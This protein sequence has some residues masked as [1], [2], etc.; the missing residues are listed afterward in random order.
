MNLIKCVLKTKTILLW[1]LLC[2]VSFAD[3]ES[4][5]VELG[6]YTVV[7][8]DSFQNQNIEGSLIGNVVMIS[9][10]HK[11]P[12]EYIL[13]HELAHLATLD[14]IKSNPT[15]FSEYRKNR[16][17]NYKLQSTWHNVTADELDNL[18][19]WNRWYTYTLDVRELV[20]E[21]LYYSVY[22]GETNLDYTI[23]PPSEED[24]KTLKNLIK[25][26]VTHGDL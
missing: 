2:S 14:K 25:N 6:Y 8:V 13:N 22:G 19:A 17:K 15:A 7:Y 12:Y 26:E 5:G 11:R 1:L 16:I 21:D 20:A 18:I 3:Y 10:G 23:G 24:I 9:K 4:E